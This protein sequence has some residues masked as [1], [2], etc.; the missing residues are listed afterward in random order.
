MGFLHPKP[1]LIAHMLMTFTTCICCENIVHFWIQL[2]RLGLCDTLV[3]KSRALTDDIIDMHAVRF[4]KMKYRFLD[5][6]WLLGDL[7]PSMRFIRPIPST[8]F[9]CWKSFGLLTSCISYPTAKSVLVPSR[10]GW[11]TGI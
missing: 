4:P 2:K 3:G 7:L 8:G 1:D 9:L 6:H 5:L 10:M 11:C